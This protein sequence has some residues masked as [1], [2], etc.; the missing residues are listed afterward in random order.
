MKFFKVRT[1][2]VNKEGMVFSWASLLFGFGLSVL[3]PILPAFIKTVV[4]NDEYVGYFYSSMSLAMLLAG[5]ISAYLFKKF[6]RISVLKIFFVVCA[7]AVTFLIFATKFYHIFFLEFSRIFSALVITISLSLMVRDFTAEKNLGQME[8]V[9]FVFSNIGWFLGPVV[10]GVIARYAGFEP[11]FMISGLL[12]LA[13]L[14]YILHQNLIKKHPS[15]ALPKYEPKKVVKTGRVR[16]FFSDKGRVAAYAI[17]LIFL[18]WLAFKAVVTPLYI[19]EQGYGSDLAGLVISLSMLPYVLIEL[20]VGKYADKHGVRNPIVCGFAIIA[21][22]LFG[23]KIS[24]IFFI[25]AALL[26]LV[27]IGSAFIEPLCDFF[28]FKHVSKE[29]ENDLYGIFRTADPAGKFLGPLIFSI[30]LM[31]LPFDWV[32]VVAGA[33]FLTAGVAALWIRG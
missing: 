22:C 14:A 9:F 2:H 19:T 12:F 31:F 13:A 10:G 32:F 3:L 7:L 18:T 28:F 27:N 29:E 17:H 23:V 30:S 20:P 8:G 6:S 21:M 25:D 33:I 4:N 16:K 15:L 24:P 5:I 1:P 11:V 26:V